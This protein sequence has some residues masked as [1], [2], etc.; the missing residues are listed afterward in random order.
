MRK[1][2]KAA[3]SDSI[4]RMN[5][6]AMNTDKSQRRN[7][8]TNSMTTT[9]A[10][11]SADSVISVIAA[12]MWRAR[13]ASTPSAPCRSRPSWTW[14]WS[15]IRSVSSMARARSTMRANRL[16]NTLSVTPIAEMRK[17]GVSAT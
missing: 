4:D 13:R 1:A 2:S 7:A 8:L 10:M 6:L 17:I 12:L 5:M 16:V 14:G 9:R 11:K 15:V 3:H